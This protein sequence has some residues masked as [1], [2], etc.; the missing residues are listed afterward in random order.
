MVWRGSG[1]AGHEARL[2]QRV[3]KRREREG[4]RERGEGERDRS[5]QA[6][7]TENKQDNG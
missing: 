2:R 4:E 7:D 6:A 3:T 1:M 5:E